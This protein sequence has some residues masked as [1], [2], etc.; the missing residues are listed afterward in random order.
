M[1]R[2]CWGRQL[3]SLFGMLITLAYFGAMA[4]VLGTGAG[5]SIHPFWLAVTGVFVIERAVT[6]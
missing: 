5:L 3:L 4:I 6:M 2:P 1:T